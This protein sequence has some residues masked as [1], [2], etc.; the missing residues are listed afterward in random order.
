MSERQERFI[1]LLRQIFE[2]DKADLDF[3]IYRILNIRRGKIES[4]FANEL[5]NTITDILKP[6][7]SEGKDEIKKKIEAMEQQAL[8]FGG[9]PDN[10]PEYQKLKS[11]LQQGTDIS[12]LESDVYSALYSFFS[13]YYDEG[14][15]IS[16]RRYKEGVY[17]I[18]YEGEEVKLYWANQDQ[19]YIKT[20][21][22]F[23]DYTFKFGDYTI[24]F[25]LVDATTEQ[26]NNKETEGKKRKFMIFQ[27]DEENYPGVKTFEFN[28]TIDNGGKIN[29]EY[30]VRFVYD[31]PAD[32]KAKW[33]EIN[34]KTI[35]DNLTVQPDTQL[36]VELLRIINPTAEPK[37]RICLLQ[38][39]LNGY[40][41][42]NTFDYFIHKDLGG[43]LTRELDFFIKN[44]IMHLDDLDTENETRVN[45]YLAK[46]RAIKRVG[47]TI[48]DFLA[49][50]ENFQKKLWLKKKFVVETNWCITLDRIDERFYDEIRNN[51]AQ[52]Q[53]WKDMYAVNEIVPDLEH[54]EP[55]TEIPSSLFLKQNQNLIIDTKHFSDDFKNR[56]IASIDNLDD[57][58]DGLLID[59]DNFHALRLI[60]EK[61]KSRIGNVI[62][63]P[64]YNT[65][66][67]GF[68]FKDN[69][70]DSSWLSMMNDRLKLV[71]DLL[72][73]NSWVTININDIELFNLM[74]LIDS[75]DWDAKNHICVK[76]SHLSGMKMSHID[77]KIPKIKEQI[78]TISKGEDASLTPIYEQC[79]WD[80]AFDRYTSWVD[81]N[82]S[83]NPS[84]WTNMSLRQAA[85]NHGVDVNNKEIYDDFKISNANHIYQRAKNDSV[86]GYPHDGKFYEICTVTG[87][88]KIILDAKEVLFASKYL[89]DIDGKLSPCLPKG[90][91]WTDIGINNAHN[92]GG[93]QL[94]NGKKPVK[95]FERLLKMYSRNNDIILDI[96]AGSATMVH[97]VLN[98]NR[99]NKYIA[100]QCGYEYFNEKT[101]RR[102]KNIVYSNEWKMDK[103]VS[104]I[105]VSQFFK[106]L[107]LESYEDALSNIELKENTGMYNQFGDEYL[108][109]YMLDIESKESLLN[110]KAFKTPFE[111]EMKIT[112]KNEC[113]QQRVDVCETFNYLIGLNVVRQ[114]EI[115][116]F[117]VKAAQ[118]PE[119]EGAVDLVSDNNGQYEFRQIEGT[120]RDGRRTL[121]I[122]RNITDDI[123]Q[124]NAAL[125]AYFTKYR[126]NPLDR[127][128]DVIYVNGDSN[129]ENLRTDDESWKVVR[130]ETEFN[131][132]MF[133]EE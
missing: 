115:K 80:D 103:P 77:K 132:R 3:G 76:M 86:A 26:N 51:K 124:S 64:P 62:T 52:V 43:F 27:E 15:F 5:P 48:I 8:S 58:C 128:F 13:R 49:Q 92:E 2:I 37:K 57:N 71:Y 130:T 69:Y 88:K 35:R 31:I 42:K 60:Y 14:D 11:Q 107:R 40:V 105:G 41:A 9:S 38:K 67:D 24:H 36:Q 90:D 74:K 102:A 44:E 89:R 28:E 110:L 47:R 59:S 95:L 96:F 119:Y 73:D 113:K 22:N 4:F 10:N 125:D 50:I 30:I 46:V 100:I 98:T 6:F 94:P 29:K 39:H 85:I 53:E 17:A 112:E 109:N 82:N 131:K 111:Y 1:E 114:G 78:V 34:F 129:L 122:W 25:R 116:Y 33:D 45:T 79:E 108:I 91:I 121:V 99:S 87:I 126:I 118:N 120:L 7:A 72:K 63:D 55:Y 106:Y 56:L 101:L 123:M 16:K 83:C 54:T 20:T 84:E 65:G 117:N 66:D 133:E 97:A 68:L 18:P 19:Y 32:P 127:E 81:Y 61:Y 23:K 93:V 12:A 70:S 21:E 75:Q 104:R